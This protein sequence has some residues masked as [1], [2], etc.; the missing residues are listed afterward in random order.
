MGKIFDFD[1]DEQ[2]DYL[3]FQQ[4][5]DAY[6][7][8]ENGVF[9]ISARLKTVRISN[10]FIFLAWNRTRW[11]FFIET[12]SPHREQGSTDECMSTENLLVLGI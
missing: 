5:L 2:F 11:L 8:N 9:N 7:A 12:P 4:F 1:M 10:G 6:D 3:A